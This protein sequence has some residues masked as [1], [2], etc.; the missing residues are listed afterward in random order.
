MNSIKLEIE[1]ILISVYSDVVISILKSHNC[2][3]VNKI[4]VFSYLVKKSKYIPSKLYTSRNSK[5]VVYKCLSLLAGDYMGYC[6]DLE[7]IFKAIHLLI[8]KK[9]IVINKQILTLSQDRV[10]EENIY[11]VDNFI[12]KSIEE[13]KKM[14]E[15]QFMKEVLYNV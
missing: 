10:N 8:S 4:L 15:R 12:Y 1:T 11:K 3:S 13:S 9:E 2:L 6:N 14:S 5:D 7:Y